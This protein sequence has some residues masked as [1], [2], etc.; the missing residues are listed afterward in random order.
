VKYAHIIKV[1][2]G[3]RGDGRPLLIGFQIEIRGARL[4]IVL[5]I[6]IYIFGTFLF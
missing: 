3:A 2:V 6:N 4:M 5:N 1:D